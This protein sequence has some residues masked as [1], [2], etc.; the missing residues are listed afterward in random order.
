VCGSPDEVCIPIHP[1][2]VS[3]VCEKAAEL[4]LLQPALL[5][6]SGPINI[7]GDIHGQFLD[8]LRFFEVRVEPLAKESSSLPFVNDVITKLYSLHSI[9]NIDWRFPTRIK[10]F[11]PW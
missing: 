4:I 8:L 9:Y 5:K 3:M 10:I 11:V 1:S 2:S 7:V 6:L